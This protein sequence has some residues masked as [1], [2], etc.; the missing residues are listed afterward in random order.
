[1]IEEHN[2]DIRYSDI[3][4]YIHRMNCIYICILEYACIHRAVSELTGPAVPGS[5][6]LRPA[7]G[8]L[9]RAEVSSISLGVGATF[10]A[11]FI[12]MLLLESTSRR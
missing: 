11:T 8:T 6:A 7:G 3:R 1:M 12:I 9:E 2:S 4:Y 5:A 10:E